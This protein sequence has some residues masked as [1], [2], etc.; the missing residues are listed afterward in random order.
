MIVKQISP[1]DCFRKC[2]KN[3][4]EN[5]HTDISVLIVDTTLWLSIWK[6]LVT[7][8][9]KVCLFNKNCFS[10]WYFMTSFTCVLREIGNTELELLKEK[11]NNQNKTFPV[12]CLL[13]SP[14]SQNSSCAM[15][16]LKLG[17]MLAIKKIILKLWNCEYSIFSFSRML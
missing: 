12:F 4:M 3:S 15:K 9:F 17:Q 2:I 16:K 5:M 11:F 14:H 1:R 6:Y 7:Y 8:L 10:K 13:F